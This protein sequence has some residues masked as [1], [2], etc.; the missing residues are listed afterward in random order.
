MTRRRAVAAVVLVLV[1]IALGAVHFSGAAFTDSSTSTVSASADDINRYLHIYSQST[2]PDH[3]TGY[4]TRR[5]TS[6]APPAATGVDH[7]LAVNMG[8]VGR[9]A[10]FTADYL[11]S[12]KI[13]PAPLPRSLTQITLSVTA[14]PDPANGMQPLVMTGVNT[15]TG[16]A[17]AKYWFS[18]DVN[19]TNAFAPNTLY[20]PHLYVTVTYTGFT[21]TYYQYDIP[22]KVYTGTGAG[23]NSAPTASRASAHGLTKS[24]PSAA[25]SA[26]AK[27][28]KPTKAAHKVKH[29]PSPAAKTKHSAKPARTSKPTPMPS[30]T[31][32]AKPTPSAAP[33]QSATP[34]PSP[35][36]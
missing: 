19:V 11:F 4:F 16:S 1:A 28:S 24:G 31:T 18:V 20:T 6:P 8:G 14:A 3:S 10:S 25:V 33:T 36:P 32:S 27:P 12:L 34:T 13:A 21:T 23:P 9:P 17:G 26:R 2:D 5:G 15:V 29:A 7:T 35:T 22:V 30:P